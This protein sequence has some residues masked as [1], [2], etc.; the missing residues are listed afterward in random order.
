MSLTPP[1]PPPPSNP[2]LKLLTCQTPKLVKKVSASP[3]STHSRQILAD[4]THQITN[5]PTSLHRSRSFNL[6]LIAPRFH[7]LSGPIT[8]SRSMIQSINSSQSSTLPTPRSSRSNTPIQNENNSHSTPSSSNLHLHRLSTALNIN[9]TSSRNL[10]TSSSL[11]QSHSPNYFHNNRLTQQRLSIDSL[12]F[13]PPFITSPTYSNPSTPL[14]PTSQTSTNQP[15]L[16][17]S[18][19]SNSSSSA[20]SSSS[21]SPHQSNRQ[22]NSLNTS[23]R[24]RRRLER[25]DGSS[26]LIAGSKRTSSSNSQPESLSKRPKRNQSSLGRL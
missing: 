10:S 17:R 3:S 25:S 14:T 1:P 15:N 5:T 23:L 13:H 6:H 18:S 12:R 20:A 7:R 16:I 4:I 11:N 9:T 22:P 2:I 24:D 19:S 21:S 8:R 26:N